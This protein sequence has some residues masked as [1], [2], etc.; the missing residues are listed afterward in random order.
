MV[1]G[2]GGASTELLNGVVSSTSS[3]DRDRRVVSADGA[4]V[5]I[6][7]GLASGCAS[8]GA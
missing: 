7:G 6:G 1:L 3:L 2:G 8:S 5:G 4:A